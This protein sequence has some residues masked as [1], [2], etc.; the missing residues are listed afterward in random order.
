MF[1]EQFLTT[2]AD[3]VADRIMARMAAQ[4]ST[5]ISQEYLTYEQAGQIIGRT[6][7]GVRYLVKNGKL[8]ICD[9]ETGRV[10]RI[11]I[12]D[13]RIYMDGIKRWAA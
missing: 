3:A 12:N 9:D 1:T 7:E 13:I 6:K 10:P 4:K 11:H 8:P 2:I 5:G